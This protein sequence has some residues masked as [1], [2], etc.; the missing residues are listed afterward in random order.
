MVWQET[1]YLLLLSAQQIPA[2]LRTLHSHGQT[3]RGGMLTGTHGLPQVSLATTVVKKGEINK[4]KK[5]ANAG[6]RERERDYNLTPFATF[7]PSSEQS[8]QR[9]A[10]ECR[11]AVIFLRLAS[12]MSSVS[13]FLEALGLLGFRV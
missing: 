5:K 8:Q 3:V 13:V 12:M 1:Y 7:R 4:E 11:E 9:R 6:G 2:S 10:N